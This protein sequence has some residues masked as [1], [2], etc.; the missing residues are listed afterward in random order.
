[1]GI[2]PH[3]Y[4][5]A[6][7]LSR[8]K[9][10]LRKGEDV[11]GAL[12]EAGYSSSSRLYERTP[13]QLGMT[14]ATYRRGGRGMRIGYAIIDSYLGYLLIAATEKGICAVSLGDTDS[15]LETALTREYPNAEIQRNDIGF[16]EWVSAI[17]KYLSGEQ[18]HLDLP[19]DIKVTAFQW[20]VYKELCA[21][22]YGITRSYGEIAEVLGHPK[23]ARAVGWACA[24]NPVS[25][26][27]P[28]HRVVQ[29]NGS[30]GGYRWGLDRKRLLLAKEQMVTSPS[31]GMRSSQ[32]IDDCLLMSMNKHEFN[33]KSKR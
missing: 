8:L 7:R 23:A 32:T 20:R 17:L 5:E 26:V 21:I 28:C 22:P 29:K 31:A 2:T 33:K 25:L 12:Y 4:A 9:I 14:P 3:R 18:P 27:I 13:V 15:V 24:I 19:M 1:M 11:T 30:L 10:L 6:Y 16:G